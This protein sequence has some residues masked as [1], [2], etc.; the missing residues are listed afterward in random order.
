MSL[1]SGKEKV[2]LRLL[3]VKKLAEALKTSKDLAEERLVTATN[4][5]APLEVGLNPLEKVC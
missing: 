3:L 4:T 1:V 2:K 5:M